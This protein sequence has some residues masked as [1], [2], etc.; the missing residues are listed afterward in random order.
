M[1]CYKP[2][3]RK[4]LAP[5]QACLTFVNQ[6]LAKNYCLLIS[7]SFRLPDVVNVNNIIYLFALKK[8]VSSVLDS[9]ASTS[10]ITSI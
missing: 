2:E 5:R 9:F 1:E 8:F 10:E 7:F 4:N 3:F 6:M